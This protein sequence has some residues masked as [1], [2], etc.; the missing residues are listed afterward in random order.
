M[1]FLKFD[2]SQ[3]DLCRKCIEKC[4]FDAL[5]IGKDG[6]IVSEKCRMCSVCVKSCPRNAIRFEQVARS[7]DKSKWKDILV[8]AEQENGDIH[9]V[10]YELIG[11]AHKLA[12][13][14][15]HDVKCVLVGGEGTAENA[16]KLLGL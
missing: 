10:V 8:Y 12:K 5:R 14:V 13:K 1:E 6:I 11:E 15:G 7:V 4:P 2:M 9:P 16:E 3:C